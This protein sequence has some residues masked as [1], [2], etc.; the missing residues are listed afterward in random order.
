MTTTFG[1]IVFA[2]IL[3]YRHNHCPRREVNFRSTVQYTCNGM[4]RQYPRNID[5]IPGISEHSF[6]ISGISFLVIV[7]DEEYPLA[8]AFWKYEPGT[9]CSICYHYETLPIGRNYVCLCNIE[10]DSCNRLFITVTRHNKACQSSGHNRTQQGGQNW[11]VAPHCTNN[12][13]KSV[14]SRPIYYKNTHSTIPVCWSSDITR[15]RPDK[16]HH[17][18]KLQNGDISRPQMV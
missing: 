14:Q 9:E 10:S 13:C 18:K 2:L 1:N 4:D 16:T 6:N 11:T 5:Q 8:L 12:S 7:N 17:N 15:V 3:N